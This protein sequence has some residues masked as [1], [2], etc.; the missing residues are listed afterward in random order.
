MCF[1]PSLDVYCNVCLISVFLSVFLPVF[2]VSLTLSES[3][4]T[5]LSSC[6]SLSV[7]RFACVQ[8]VCQ[9]LSLF[10]SFYDLLVVVVIIVFVIIVVFIVAHVDVWVVPFF[11]M[12]VMNS[13]QMVVPHCL[14][15]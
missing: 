1:L 5:C 9:C 7:S 8:R 12:P 11:S 10:Q 6:Q 4:D 13:L 15:V 3:L 2:Q 14:F